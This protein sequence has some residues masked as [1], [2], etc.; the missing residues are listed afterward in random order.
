M[1]VTAVRPMQSEDIAVVAGWLSAVP[2]W[3]RY[4]LTE[5]RALQLLDQALQRADVLLVADSDDPGGRACG[6]AWCL[7]AGAFG[8]SAYLRILG[9]HPDRA[10]QG[11]GAVLL[12]QAEAT[13]A[14]SCDDLFLLVAD[15][16]TDAQRFYERQG[17]HQIGVIP[18]YVLPDVAELLYWK[19]LRSLV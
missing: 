9:V 11:I 10:G 12:R 8:R 3:Q 15:F 19:R 13:V 16:N 1:A 6:L 5:A 18:G 17:Y 2:L 7:P 4:H 14:T